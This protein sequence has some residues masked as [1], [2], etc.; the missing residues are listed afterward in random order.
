MKNIALFKNQ[1]KQ[2]GDNK[3]DYNLTASWQDDQGNWQSVTVG[4]LWR[5]DN[6]QNP[7]APALSGKMANARTSNEGKQFP[8]FEIKREGVPENATPAPTQ[9]DNQQVE[10]DFDSV[11]F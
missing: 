6:S 4:S 9:E 5:Q 7:N 2:E 1:N 8:G 3:P 11:P 10:E